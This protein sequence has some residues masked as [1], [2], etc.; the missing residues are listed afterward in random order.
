MR[1]FLI[2]LF[3]VPFSL[4]SVDDISI[5]GTPGVMTISTA[6]AGS[7]PDDVSDAT[8]TYDISFDSGTR[9]ITG[10]VDIAIPSNTTL[11]IT[12]SPPAGATGQGAQSLTTAAKDLVTSIS[13]GSY[14]SLTITY[15]FSAT[16]TAG[17]FTT[18]NRLVTLTI[19]DTT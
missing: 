7:D 19:V 5:T 16:A 2:T 15:N 6:T 13:S 4:F 11:N 3:L 18:T 8:T 12:L 1:H 17:T 9:K 10:Q 14:S